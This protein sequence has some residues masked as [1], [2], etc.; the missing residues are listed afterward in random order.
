M[1]YIK[2]NDTNNLFVLASEFKTLSNPTYLWRL[3]NSQGKESYTF[4]PENITS[5]YPSAYTLKY[6]VFS[7]NTNKNQPVNYI[8]SPGSPVNLHL[9]DEN[10]YWIGIYE[11]SS[12]TNLN[13]AFGI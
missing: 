7:F 13:V 9:K 5:T 4:I 6:D 3:Q 8:F 2:Q 10:Q 12:P 1:L 11:Q